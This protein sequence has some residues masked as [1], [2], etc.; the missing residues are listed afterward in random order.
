MRNNAI[1]IDMGSVNT[2]IYQLGS[3]VVLSEPS[4]VALSVNGKSSIRAVGSEAK[5]LIGKTAETTKIVFPIVEGEIADI[6]NATAMTENFLNKITLRKLSLRPKALVSVPCGIENDEIKKY[7]KVL[8]GA[9]VY[10]ADFVESPIL[11][12]L[13]LGIPVSESTPCFIIDVGGGTTNIAA[14]SLDGVIAGVNVNM[15]GRNVDA[16]IIN[17]IADLFGLRI[18]MLT[19]EKI[20]T[21]IASL[22]EGDA[23][24]TVIN[25]RDI[26][27]G[28]PRSVSVSA[29]D[30]LLP[31]A[32]FFD[33]IFEIASMVMAK[34]PAEVSAEIRRSGVY[35]SGGVSR[36]PGLDGYFREH[37]AIRANVFEDPEMTAAIGGGILLG[38]EKLLKKLR[39]EKK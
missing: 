20:K 15:G 9:G 39:I 31:V 24:R 11:T 27:S 5:K 19:A 35:F 10:N 38:N 32:A 33:K 12:A 14:V 34:L 30:V 36:L 21:Q 7:A 23:T 6:K 13:G 25:G 22:I 18:G 28:K 17:R 29:S 2:V 26:E 16:M 3:G 1:A 8:S 37:M 4:V